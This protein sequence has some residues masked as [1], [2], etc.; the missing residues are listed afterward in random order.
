MRF[1]VYTAIPATTLF[2]VPQARADDPA[3]SAEDLMASLKGAAPDSLIK[4]A[5][6]MNMADMTV[7]KKGKNGWTCMVHGGVPMCVDDVGLDWVHALMS[8]SA[9]PEKIGLIYMLKGD[10][11]VS[12]TD[13]FAKAETPDNN[14]VKT[15]PHIMIVGG[16]KALAQGLPNGARPDETAPYVMWPGTPYEHLMLPTE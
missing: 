15:G 3:M 5:T 9:P 6:L 16:V 11:G 14:W 1:A 7:V 4:D 12:N 13:P 8:K 10:A 2:A